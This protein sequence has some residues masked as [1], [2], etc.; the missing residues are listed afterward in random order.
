MFFTHE[1]QPA[2]DYDL[3]CIPTLNGQLSGRTLTADMC[4]VTQQD[5]EAER[6]DR[7]VCPDIDHILAMAQPDAKVFGAQLADAAWFTNLAYT[8]TYATILSQQFEKTEQK[9]WSS[10]HMIALHRTDAVF[11]ALRKGNR[12]NTVWFG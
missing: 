4:N 3:L 2:R 9:N 5:A 7:V 6:D 10:A 12:K 1:K 11:I 8:G